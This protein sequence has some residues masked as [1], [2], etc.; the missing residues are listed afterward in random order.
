M[1]VS[2]GSAIGNLSTDLS[3]TI[4]FVV[5]TELLSTARENGVN[6]DEL[7]AAI[8]M[9]GVALKSIPRGFAKVIELELLPKA[10]STTSD[11]TRGV[12]GFLHTLVDIATRISISL[13]I[14]LLAAGVRARSELRSV[15]VIT[16]LTLAIF[17][18]VSER[19]SSLT[20]RPRSD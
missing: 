11:A 20:S 9:I 3:V 2:A 14:Q 4:S 19:A 13:A 18:L 12:F 8:L 7:I 1:D 16:L 17:F 6:E 15:R 10:L 5:A